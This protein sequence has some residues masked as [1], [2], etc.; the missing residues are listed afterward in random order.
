M[1]NT[2]K[3][4]ALFH[5]NLF[6]RRL[7][8]VSSVILQSGIITQSTYLSPVYG[9]VKNFHDTYLEVHVNPEEANIQHLFR[10]SVMGQMP[11][12]KCRNTI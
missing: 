8:I 10:L 11:L 5:E 4:Y 9:F 7:N 1:H 3:M 12:H 2:L 6:D